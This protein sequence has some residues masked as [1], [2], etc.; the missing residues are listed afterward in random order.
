M[1]ASRDVPECFG[2]LWEPQDLDCSGGYN[3]AYTGE[4]GSKQQP[5]CSF[6]EACRTRVAINKAQQ[7]RATAQ[8][9][10][11]QIS[12]GLVS[13]GGLTRNYQ[14]QPAVAVA[15]TVPVPIPVP[16][17]PQGGQAANGQPVLY[18]RPVVQTHAYVPPYLL[19]PEPTGP[20]EHFMMPLGR[21][22]TRAMMK[23]AGQTFANFWD[24]TTLRRPGGK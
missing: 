2:R 20:D 7:Q 22:M 12:P 13:V 9:G 15:P 10:T 23:A 24:Y 8:Q 3:P 17:S 1:V 18:Q 14:P 6:F 5:R 21:E 4:N 16:V 11:A 19:V